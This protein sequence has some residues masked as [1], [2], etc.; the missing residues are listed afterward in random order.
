MKLASDHNYHG[1][2]PLV[3]PAVI[4]RIMTKSATK[5][6]WWE[7]WRKRKIKKS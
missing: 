1:D 5:P 4:A 3:D 7:R 6:K 2:R